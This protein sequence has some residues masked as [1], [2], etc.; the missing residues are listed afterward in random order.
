MS[1]L[2]EDILEIRKDIAELKECVAFLRKE[3][4]GRIRQGEEM[5]DWFYDWLGEIDMRLLPLLWAVCP[6]LA[7]TMSA[8]HEMRKGDTGS[9]EKP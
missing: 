3:N 8:D 5:T 2:R 9:G 7:E 1:L 4:Q 6:D